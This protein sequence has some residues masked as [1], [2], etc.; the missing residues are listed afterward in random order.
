MKR[1]ALRLTILIFPQPVVTPNDLRV[2]KETPGR[3]L[4]GPESRGHPGP[5]ERVTNQITKQLIL[6]IY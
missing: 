1:H 5:E 6:F 4:L 3:Q 2:G